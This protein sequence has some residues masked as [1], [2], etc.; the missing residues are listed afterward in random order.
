MM[1]PSGRDW[2]AGSWALYRHCTHRPLLATEPSFSRNAQHGSIKTSVLT[3]FGSMPGPFQKDAVSL[4]NRLTTTIQSRLA[5]AARVLFELA[6]LHAG[7]WP[8]EKKPVN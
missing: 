3:F 1:S 6:P 8:H 5:M 7:F 4:S 2:P